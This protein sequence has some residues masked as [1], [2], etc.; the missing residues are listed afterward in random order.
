MFLQPASNGDSGL[1]VKVKVRFRGSDFFPGRELLDGQCRS[2]QRA[3]DV[4]AVAGTRAGAQDPASGGDLA[5]HDDIGHDFPRGRK[6]AAGQLN[7]EPPR[8]RLQT[9]KESVNP[10]LLQVP[11]QAERKEACQRCTAH[12]SDIAQAARQAAVANTLRGVPVAAEMYVLDGKVRGDQKFVAGAGTQ[13]G[14]V[15]ADSLRYGSVRWRTSQFSDS[16]DQLPFSHRSPTILMS[17]RSKPLASFIRGQDFPAPEAAGSARKS[18]S[19]VVFSVA[20][21]QAAC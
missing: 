3:G 19:R 5:E 4:D 21:F 12:G 14:A 8:Q 20:S 7:A 17:L 11:R 18:A 13:D 16:L 9:S 6:I 1:R 15:V 2:A 10:S